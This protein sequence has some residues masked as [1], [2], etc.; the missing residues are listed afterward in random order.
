[1]TFLGDTLILKVTFLSQ[2]P[3]IIQRRPTSVIRKLGFGK[4]IGLEFLPSH[5]MIALKMPLSMR[6]NNQV[7]KPFDIIVLNSFAECI[8]TCNLFK[9]YSHDLTY[10]LT[11]KWIPA[12]KMQAA[13]FLFILLGLN[14]L[15]SVNCGKFK[16]NLVPWVKSM[17]GETRSGT[18]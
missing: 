3:V 6:L 8:L 11:Y 9:N 14:H 2:S 17:M 18:A 5:L 13:L 16:F 10:Q 7:I 4:I 15:P 12:C 1:M